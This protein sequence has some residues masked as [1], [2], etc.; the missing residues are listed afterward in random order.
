VFPTRYDARFG[1]RPRLSTLRAR[2]LPNGILDV[3]VQIALMQ[4]TYMAYRLVR[5]WIDDPQGAAVAFENGRT[6]IEFERATGLF[7]EPA[8]Q[9]LFGATSLIGDVSAWIYL[10]AQV[11]VTLAALVFLYVAHNRSFY[12]VRNMF[13]LSWI[14][15]LAGYALYPTA[16]PRF[17]PEWGFVDS[18]SDFTGVRPDSAAADALFNPY[19]AVP[20]MHVAF[21]LMIAV[22]L[23]I[24]CKHRVVRW[25]WTIYP[26]VVTFVIVMTANHFLVDAILGAMTAGLA[27]AGAMSLARA[28]PAWGFQPQ[29]APATA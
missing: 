29:P 5:G 25:F 21:A 18:V 14:V 22:P 28:R 17:F 23:S 24:L 9:E 7:I 16:P 27:A 10:N 2:L 19:A 6:I 8:V 3:V 15:A 20:S 1:M 12:F 26:V 4:A 13:I 11:T